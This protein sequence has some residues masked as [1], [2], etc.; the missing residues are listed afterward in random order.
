MVRSNHPGE[1]GSERKD[2]FDNLSS[3]SHH[4]Y[5]LPLRLLNICHYYLQKSFSELILPQWSDYMFKSQ[6]SGHSVLQAHVTIQ[7]LPIMVCDTVVESI[8]CLFLLSWI[9]FVKIFGSLSF[10]TIS[11]TAV[12]Q[13]GLICYLHMIHS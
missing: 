10:C 3:R 9:K 12:Y 5:W 2:C 8:H 7:F 13:W 1:S 11:L 4:Q 6:L